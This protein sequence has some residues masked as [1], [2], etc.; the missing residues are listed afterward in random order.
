M[1]KSLFFILLA[2]M[3][4][5]AG[6]GPQEKAKTIA[7]TA[8]DGMGNKISFSEKPK[9]IVANTLNLEE[10]VLAIVGAERM[11][12]ISADA[13]TE[14]LGFLPEEAQK[15]RKVIPRNIGQEQLLALK[16]DLVIIQE[17]DK[18]STQALR[19]LGL[20]IFVFTVPDAVE[21]VMDRIKLIAAAT[22][23]E[24]K[25]DSIVANMKQVM[26]KIDRRLKSIPENSRKIGIAYSALGAFGVKGGVYDEISNRAGIQN[27]AALA[28]LAR[29]D[30]LSKESIIKVNPDLFVFP[31]RLDVTKG[32]KDIESIRKEIEEDPAFAHIKAVEEKR[33]IYINDRYRYAT[34]PHI[35]EAIK[36][37]HEA[38]Y[39]PLD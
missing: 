3:V 17:R 18:A 19:E 5:L 27:G 2:L 10:T 1:K 34:S 22:G 15:V 23:D 13:R 7:Y 33:Y 6:C 11:V 24:E 28:G 4:F 31:I 14:G 26:D 9:R 20:P 39:G 25:G 36:T 37:L 21:S 35:V 38:V 30:H 8:V 16:P 29:G 12:G 32:E